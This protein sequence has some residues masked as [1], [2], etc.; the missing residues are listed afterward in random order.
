M[1]HCTFVQTN[2]LDKERHNHWDFNFKPP[3]SFSDAESNIIFSFF[4]KLNLLLFD[5]VVAHWHRGDGLQDCSKDTIGYLSFKSQKMQEIRVQ[6]LV[7]DHVCKLKISAKNRNCLRDDESWIGGRFLS[8]VVSHFKSTVD[9]HAG[10]ESCIS[11]AA[12][13]RRVL[14]RVCSLFSCS[15]AVDQPLLLTFQRSHGILTETGSEGALPL[16]GPATVSAGL[17]LL[18]P[19]PSPPSL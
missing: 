15:P 16:Q 1:L 4:W 9:A 18:L 19:L 3:E 14:L 6:G 5:C 13:S 12:P 7:F 11:S 17:L 2:S 8:A 10:C